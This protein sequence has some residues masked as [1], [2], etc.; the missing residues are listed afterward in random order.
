MGVVDHLFIVKHRLVTVVQ[1]P[2][3]VLV[4]HQFRVALLLVRVQVFVH[5]VVRG[6]QR[7]LVHHVVAGQI[8]EGHPGVGV[9]D[10][11]THV[12]VD[13]LLHDLRVP[14]GRLLDQLWFHDHGSPA[15]E[16]DV[17]L[18]LGFV[19]AAAIVSVEV[20]DVVHAHNS[21]DSGGM[22]KSLGNLN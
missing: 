5:L 7:R 1:R 8:H 4:D 14:V 10:V 3:L 20:D 16:D 9:V 13:A 2:V 12:L 6:L 21:T 17:Q 22:N 18:G 15:M 11:Q 19:G